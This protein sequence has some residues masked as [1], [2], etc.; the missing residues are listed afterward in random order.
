MG[1]AK[2]K[3]ALLESNPLRNNRRELI[4]WPDGRF[5]DFSVR[6]FSE[7]RNR[8]RNGSRSAFPPTSCGAFPHFLQF[9][10][11]FYEINEINELSHSRDALVVG[12]G[13]CSGRFRLCASGKPAFASTTSRPSKSRMA[14]GKCT[15]SY[16]AFTAVGSHQQS[17]TAPRRGVC[18]SPTRSKLPVCAGGIQT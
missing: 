17:P 6:L 4:A 2:R 1:P 9:L 10:T 18:R 13:P 14:L 7:P 5:K 11:A 12:S 8:F 15:C 3:R 16:S